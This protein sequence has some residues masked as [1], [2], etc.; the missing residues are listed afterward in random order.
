MRDLNEKTT[1]WKIMVVID[2]EFYFQTET[3]FDEKKARK[4]YDLLCD[5]FDKDNVYPTKTI[6]TI[7]SEETDTAF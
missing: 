6:T 1:N 7:V 2:G 3:I 4:V 5:S